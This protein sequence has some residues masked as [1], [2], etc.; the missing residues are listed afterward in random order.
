MLLDVLKLTCFEQDLDAR[1]QITV[2]G[3]GVLV[4]G[5]VCDMRIA[6]NDCW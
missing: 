1:H 4:H 5:G 3:F 6:G 2:A